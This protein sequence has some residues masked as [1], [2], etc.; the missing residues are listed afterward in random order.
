MNSA[1]AFRRMSSVANT[2]DAERIMK[3]LRPEVG[4]STVH[5][6]FLNPLEGR[7]RKLRDG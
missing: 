5:H 4:L 3:S 1:L 7:L 2:G 6:T